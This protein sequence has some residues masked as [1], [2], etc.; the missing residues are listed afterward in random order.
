[1]FPSFGLTSSAD[2][3]STQSSLLPDMG[4]LSLSTE[5]DEEDEEDQVPEEKVSQPSY[6]QRAMVTA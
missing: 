4:L 3:T 6:L 5:E 1:M 2:Q